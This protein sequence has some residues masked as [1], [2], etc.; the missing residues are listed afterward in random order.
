MVAAPKPPRSRKEN[1]HFH[2]AHRRAGNRE[3]ARRYRK[4]ESAK[5]GDT[6][7]CHELLRLFYVTRVNYPPYIG[8]KLHVI[9]MHT[10]MYN[11]ANMA[12]TR[13]LL[14]KSRKFIS[15]EV[16]NDITETLA[17]YRIRDGYYSRVKASSSITRAFSLSEE[18]STKSEEVRRVDKCKTKAKHNIGLVYINIAYMKMILEHL[19]PVNFSYHF[20]FDHLKIQK[21]IPQQQINIIKANLNIQQEFIEHN[22]PTAMQFCRMIEVVNQWSKDGALSII[23]APSAPVEQQQQQQQQQQDQPEEAEEE[24]I[25]RDPEEAIILDGYYTPAELAIPAQT[26]CLIELAAMLPSTTPTIDGFLDS[27]MSSIAI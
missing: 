3:A 9:N 17:K 27:M 21:N 23:S 6:F 18:N 5:T 26:P 25:V 10:K 24:T 11:F 2:S 8:D 20:R 15:P 13:E 14:E 4:R 19:I 22:T 16:Y 7:D 12:K 1:D